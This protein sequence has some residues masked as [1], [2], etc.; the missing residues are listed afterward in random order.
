VRESLEE[1]MGARAW[2]HAEGAVALF[3]Q[4]RAWLRRER[5]LLPAVSVLARLVSSVWEEAAQCAYRSLA[6][7]AAGAVVE[8]PMRL[9]D[10]LE[11]PEGKKVSELE[12][13]R[14]A[15]RSDSGLAMSKALARVS[16]V[17]AIG[18]GAAQVQAVPV[19]RVAALARYGWAGNAPLLKGTTSTTS[20]TR[21]APT[22]ASAPT[23]SASS[24]QRSTRSAP[25]TTTSGPTPRPGSCWCST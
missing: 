24:S 10:L 2:I 4:T 19:N 8:L 6:Q 13:L 1:F 11:V 9:R 20:S 17:L 22:A 15:P 7:A 14:T 5:V 18:A 12:R 21:W 3:E 25:P 23:R 16:E